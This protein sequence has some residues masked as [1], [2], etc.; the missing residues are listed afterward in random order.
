MADQIQVRETVVIDITDIPDELRATLRS[1]LRATVRRVVNGDVASA[2]GWTVAAVESLLSRLDQG[3]Y[4]VQAASVR[5]ALANG[6]HIT[7]SA[8]YK[9]GKYPSTRSLKG[10]TRSINR[11]ED[12]MRVS[13]EIEP[14]A[15]PLFSTSYQDGVKADGF[16]VPGAVADLYYTT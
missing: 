6:S 16:S 10:F 12:Q 1:A 15:D 2:R 7:R 14:D 11:I 9:I 13:A 4:K 5:E 3:G 8:V